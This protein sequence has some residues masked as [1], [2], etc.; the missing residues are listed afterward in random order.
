MLRI[1]GKTDS[2]NVATVARRWAG[3]F[4]RSG[5]RGYRLNTEVVCPAILTLLLRCE[6]LKLPDCRAFGG[7]KDIQPDVTGRH[8]F[9]LTR[10]S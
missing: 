7:L 10:V 8:W 2:A 3:F 5:D 1:T 6:K 9:K 4:P